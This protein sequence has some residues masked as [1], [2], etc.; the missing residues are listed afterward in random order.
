MTAPPVATLASSRSTFLSGTLE[1]IKYLTVNHDDLTEICELLIENTESG[2]AA[3]VEA[4]EEVCDPLDTSG[5][6]LYVLPVHPVS[7]EQ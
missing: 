6:Q 3:H 4:V 1:L 5:D 7:L 2:S